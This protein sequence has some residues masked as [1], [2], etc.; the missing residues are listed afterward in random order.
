MT[1]QEHTHPALPTFRGRSL[2]ITTLTI[3]QLIIGVIHLFFGFWLLVATQNIIDFSSQTSN[4]IYDVYTIIFGLSATS[5]A[6]GI[7][8]QKNWGLYGTIAI[9]LFVTVVDSLTLLYLPSIPG[10]PQFAAGPEIIYSLFVIIYLSQ[11][12][13]RNKNKGRGKQRNSLDCEVVF[14]QFFGSRGNSHFEFPIVEQTYHLQ[15]SS[16]ARSEYP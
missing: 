6:F 13:A 3:L 10:V 5:F 11:T 14:S 15:I 2:G 1:F 8:L 7:W 16:I 12:G 9:S 4:T